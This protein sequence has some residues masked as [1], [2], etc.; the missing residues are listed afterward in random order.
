MSIA[1]SGSPAQSNHHQ[2]L[3]SPLVQPDAVPHLAAAQAALAS[4]Q[5]HAVAWQADTAHFG[6]DA[7]SMNAVQPVQ[8]DC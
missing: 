4:A 2:A 7:P 6:T 3:L 5:M 1:N 8:Q